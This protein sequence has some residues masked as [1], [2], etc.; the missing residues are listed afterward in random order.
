MRK[1]LAL[2][3]DELIKTDD[4]LVLLFG[5]VGTYGF[6]NAQAQ[7]PDRVYNVGILEQSMISMAAGL[8]MQDFIPVVHTIAAF[9]VERSLE[10]IKDDFGYQRLGGNFVSI[11]ASYD[12]ASWGST[13]ECP[14]DIGILKNVPEVE[15]VVPG[16]ASEF[17]SLFKQSYKNG[18]PT[19][20]RLSN[21]NNA[22]SQEVEFGKAHVIRN[23][24]KATVI[25]VGPM[26]DRVQEA[27]KDFDVTIL[28]YTTLQPFDHDTLRKNVHGGR[29]IVCEPYYSG[30]LA[31]DI[32]EATA[33]Q[34][35]R[36]EHVGVPHEFIHRYG[37]M[38]DIDTF[39]GLNEGGIKA[40]IEKILDNPTDSS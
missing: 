20:F 24:K 15:I 6:R 36:I 8:A 29:I 7:F 3:I 13:H 22:A 21:K 31:A 11:G 40:K 17:D 14:G 18:H 34:P 2:T 5:D 10:Q 4:K 9:L 16:S 27:C 19:Y 32:S 38:D 33:P 1:Q 30:A 12:L 39:L 35:I 37:T 25:A 23:G 26:L 28:Y